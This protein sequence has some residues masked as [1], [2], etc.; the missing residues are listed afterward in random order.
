MPSEVA[1]D[2]P[3]QNKNPASRHSEAPLSKLEEPV[4]SSSKRSNISD[5][6]NIANELER[7]YEAQQVTAI[8]DSLHVNS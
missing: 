4:E 6:S 1:P 2:E 8:N 3:V 5:A 7:I